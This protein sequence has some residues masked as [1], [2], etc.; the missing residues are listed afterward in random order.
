MS[1]PVSYDVTLS[2]SDG[3]TIVKIADT[4]YSITGLT[5]DISYN[6]TVTSR[7]EAGTGKAAV[8]IFRIPPEE[9]AVLN[10][11]LINIISFV[12]SVKWM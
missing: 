8:M 7:N 12:S 11:K 10:G 9:E 5:P 4:S 3:V 6:V 2:P 1:V